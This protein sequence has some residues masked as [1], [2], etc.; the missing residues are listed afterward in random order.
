MALF[1]HETY[2]QSER[3][4]REVNVFECDL[5]VTPDAGDS[6][7]QFFAFE[8]VER[9]SEPLSVGHKSELAGVH[10]QSH[11]KRVRNGVVQFLKNAMS[12]APP[13]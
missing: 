13:I 12:H 9:P 4:A 3:R 1:V 5:A 11:H 8:S 2:L 10:V 7:E 6:R